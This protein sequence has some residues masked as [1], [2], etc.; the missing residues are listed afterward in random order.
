MKCSEL[1]AALENVIRVHGDVPVVSGS[2]GN[3]QA[4]VG[5]L[6]LASKGMVFGF[7]EGVQHEMV[8]GVFPI[9]VPP[10]DRP[11]DPNKYLCLDARGGAKSIYEQIMEQVADTLAKGETAKLTYGDTVLLVH[12]GGLIEGVMRL[13][14]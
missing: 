3:P 1:V 2:P 12:P 13:Q 6:G 9:G 5:V 4:P 14:S 11:K 10:S 7:H 8:V